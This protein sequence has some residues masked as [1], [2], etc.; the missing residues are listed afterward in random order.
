MEPVVRRTVSDVH[1]SPF[2]VRAVGE[3]AILNVV[4]VAIE[5]FQVP[6]DIAELDAVNS[7]VRTTREDQWIIDTRDN[8][9]LVLIV[10]VSDTFT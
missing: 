6:A 1:P 5:H 3:D 8:S 7:D 2:P 9:S 10:A 4:V